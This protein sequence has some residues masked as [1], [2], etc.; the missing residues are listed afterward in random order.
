M[1]KKFTPS[2][3]ERIENLLFQVGKDFFGRFGLRKT[4]I[5]ELT[6]AAGIGQGTFYH[7]FSSKEEL[8]FR[9]LEQEERALQK[10]FLENWGPDPESF[11]NAF[12]NA[13]KEIE[14]NPILQ[15]LY[16]EDEYQNLL[17]K[18]PPELIEEHIERDHKTLSSISQFFPHHNPNAIAGLFRALFLI[19]LHKKEI[20]SQNYQET[21]DLLLD[22]VAQ[23]LT[24]EA[25]DSGS[26]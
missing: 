5:R 11:K 20:G 23:G 8:Y 10:S 14:N 19:S 17:K 13:F 25:R 1:T 22:L 9:L 21:L 12:L 7:F 16:L 24:R 3:K 26:N 6:R 4:S 18:L 2:E 15:Q